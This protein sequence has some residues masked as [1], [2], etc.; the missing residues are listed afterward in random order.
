MRWILVFSMLIS[1]NG[2][3]QLK[4]YTISVKGDTL[5]ATDVK[6]LKQG[7]WL[8]RYDEVRGEP[9]FEEEGEYKDGRKEGVWRKYTLMGDLLAVENYRWGYKDGLNLYYNALGELLRE[10][11]WMA[12]NPDKQYDTIDVE[13][14]DALGTFTRMIVKNEGASIRHGTWRYYDPSSGSSKTESYTIGKLDKGD[15]TVTASTTTEP[16]T[17]AK[18]KEVMDFEK[19]NAGK[20]KIKVRDGSTF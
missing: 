18:P 20:K 13:N 19:K 2:F 12:L 1:L 5:N 16:K 9:G 8:H 10:E 15:K 7:K 11:R 3:S 17:K 14:V 4:D 6:G